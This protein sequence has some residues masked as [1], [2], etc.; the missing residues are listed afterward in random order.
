MTNEMKVTRDVCKDCGVTHVFLEDVKLTESE[1]DEMELLQTK[2]TNIT[3]ALR[4][5][6]IPEGTPETKIA[7]Y[8]KGCLDSKAELE[9]LIKDWWKRVRVTYN[10]DPNKTFY[11]NSYNNKL[12]YNE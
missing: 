8:I 6:V 1:K 9:F 11:Y 10:L 7:G 12:Y 4:L 5:D 3:Q 2:S